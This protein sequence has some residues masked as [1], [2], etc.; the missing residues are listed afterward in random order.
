MKSI[1]SGLAAAACAL[2]ISG[3]ALAELYSPAGT[4]T[5]GHK[6]TR[7]EIT[8]CGDGDDMC[9]KVVWLKDGSPEAQRLVNTTVVDTARRVGNQEWYGV[10]N[11]AGH[12][13]RGTLTLVDEDTLHIRACNGLVCGEFDLYRE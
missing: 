12:R 1:I 6:D 8:L 7:Y 9:A 5:T 2:L 4:W 13:F 11:I 10:T 3:P